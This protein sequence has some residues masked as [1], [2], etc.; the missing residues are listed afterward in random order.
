MAAA[1]SEADMLALVDAIADGAWHSGETLA[2]GFGIS[3]AALAKRIDKLSDWQLQVE[4]RQGLGYR[5]VP[6][7]QRLDAA[8]LQ[9]AVPGLH[10]QVAALVDS[11]NTRLLEADAALDPQ[12][13][14]AELQTAGRG[15][16]GRSWVS[17]FG[18]NLY[19]S[20]AWS[21]PTW[22]RELTA[23]S[24]AVGVACARVL[25]DAGLHSLRLKWPND[26]LVHNRK[27][28][29]ILIEHR[30]EAGGG[31]RV[32]IG[33]GINLRMVE[34]QA[35]EVTQPWTTLDAAL[36]D[37]G[38]VPLHRQ[39]LAAALLASLDDLLRH[40]AEHGFSAIAAQ[41]AAFDATRDAAVR[42]SGSGEP[43]LGIA[44][45]VDRDG[46]LIVEAEDGVRHRLHAG[47]VS[48]RLA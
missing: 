4:S 13:L 2:A 31:C 9:A 41:W 40:Y 10:V 11:T 18:A 22:P 3:R 16:R 23:L 12:A 6:P 36:R 47:E 26:L 39:A 19:L 35:A 20:L 8:A 32:V 46:A 17:P 27:L 38:A 14:F 48:L 43:L 45:G 33:I 25:R 28:G 21:W 37:D 1:L 24:L 5:L 30:G 15:R 34:A 44:R 7:L 42:I 29:G